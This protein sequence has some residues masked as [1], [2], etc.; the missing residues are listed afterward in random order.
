MYVYNGLQIHIKAVKRWS[1]QILTLTDD[2]SHAGTRPTLKLST[3]WADKH[4]T[5][6]HS[7]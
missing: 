5:Q 3:A 6:P 2:D 7:A 1:E 4:E